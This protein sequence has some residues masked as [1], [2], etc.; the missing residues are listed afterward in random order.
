MKVLICERCELIH[1][2]DYDGLTCRNE[3]CGGHLIPVNIDFTKVEGDGESPDEME[4]P[5][6]AS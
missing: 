2:I 3:G 1:P 6:V 5:I 4:P